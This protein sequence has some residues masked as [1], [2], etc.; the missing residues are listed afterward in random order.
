MTQIL[1]NEAIHKKSP[2]EITAL[3]YEACYTNLEKAIKEIENK[4][5]I[6]AN[7]YL[8]KASDII[9]RLGAGINYEAGI[10]ADQLDSLY[11]YIADK[12]IE[13]NYSKNIEV[14]REVLQVL[15]E[16]M[17]SWNQALR[18]NTDTQPKVIKRKVSVYDKMSIY[19]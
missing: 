11:N 8:Q 6:E 12:I 16:I 19:E 13:A 2:Q 1:T 7:I 14:I 17:T 9:E 10:I 15:S 5:F 3:L 18:K 4:Q